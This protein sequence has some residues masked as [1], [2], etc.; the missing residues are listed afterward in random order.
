MET[1]RSPTIATDVVG[2]A[3]TEPSDKTAQIITTAA[4]ALF[5]LRG[6]ERI[7]T[8]SSTTVA[9]TGAAGAPG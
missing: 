7:V 1:R 8:I 9:L 4:A 6:I 2:G 5:K 3:N